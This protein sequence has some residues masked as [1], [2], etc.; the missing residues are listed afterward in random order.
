MTTGSAASW[1]VAKTG[2]SVYVTPVARQN[3]DAQP[4]S[5]TVTTVP[6][7]Q[8]LRRIAPGSFCVRM[9]CVESARSSAGSET[10]LESLL[11]R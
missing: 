3:A 10:S 9:T 11:S 6:E 4:L 1:A 5:L 8:Y 2:G 7:R